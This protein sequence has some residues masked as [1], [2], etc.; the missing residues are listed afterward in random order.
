MAL[1][2]II[3]IDEELCNG[4]GN[5]ITG[6]A[7]GALQLIDGKARLVKETYCDGFGDCIGTCPTGALKIIEREGEEFDFNRTLKYVEEIRGEEGARLM[8]ESHKIH[9]QKMSAAQAPRGCPGS[10]FRSGPPAQSAAAPVA[11][12]SMPVVM[13]SELSQWPVQLHLLPTRAS[14]FDNREMVI[15]S[16]CSPAT[17]PDV[18]WRYIRGRSVAIACPKL[19][20]TEGYVEKL[21]EIFVSNNIPRVIILRMEV[22]CC[23]GLTAMVKAALERSKPQGLVVDEVTMS[24]AGEIIKTSRIY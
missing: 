2:K 24:L 1:R 12:G 19:D 5:C 14:F 23:G 17:S 10:M 7:E 3:S 9:E 18:Q 11:D 8:R 6:C 13:K 16:T 21:A 4:C 20:R 22:P 15:L